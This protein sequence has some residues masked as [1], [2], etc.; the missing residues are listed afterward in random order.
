MSYLVKTF[1]GQCDAADYKE[2]ERKAHD[3]LLDIITDG[4][5]CRY[6]FVRLIDTQRMRFKLISCVHLGYW[7]FTGWF[8]YKENLNTK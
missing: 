4:F 3:M 6:W 7:R 2:A 1:R 8:P 5:D